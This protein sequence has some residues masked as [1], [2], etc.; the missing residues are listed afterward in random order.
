[1]SWW[2]ISLAKAI[3]LPLQPLSDRR[4]ECHLIE[5]DGHDSDRKYYRRRRQT[6]PAAI[7]SLLAESKMK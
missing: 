3:E 6:V 7:Q 1:M 5:Y 2:K 4:V